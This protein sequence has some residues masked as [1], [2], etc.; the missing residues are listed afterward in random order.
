MVWV[1]RDVDGMARAASLVALAC[2]V[3]GRANALTTITPSQGLVVVADRWVVGGW[4]IT[5]GAAVGKSPASALLAALLLTQ[6]TLAVVFIRKHFG[7]G[8]Q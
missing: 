5:L 2:G 3:L 7:H 1:E 4:I 8:H 6:M